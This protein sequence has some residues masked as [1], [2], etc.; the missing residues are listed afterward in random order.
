MRDV[1]VFRVL[2]FGASYMATMLLGECGLMAGVGAIVGS[3][4]AIWLFGGTSRLGA[5]LSYAG[6]LSMTTDAALIAIVTAVGVALLSALAP[7]ATALRE[8][9]F[10]VLSRAI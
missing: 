4:L 2:G 6:Y 1:A 10:E 3:G 7:I 8:S 5:I 9:P